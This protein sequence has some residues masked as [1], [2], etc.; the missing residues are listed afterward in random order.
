MNMMLYVP[1]VNRMLGV[2]C[3]STWPYVR[4]R[5]SDEEMGAYIIQILRG[6][7]I[8]TSAPRCLLVYTSNLLSGLCRCLAK[9]SL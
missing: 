7:L 1:M 3:S 8:P 2:K 6:F 9:K 4:L 5:S